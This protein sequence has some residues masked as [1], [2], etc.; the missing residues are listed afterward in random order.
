MQGN[1]LANKSAIDRSKTDFYPIGTQ[2]GERSFSIG[3]NLNMC[4]R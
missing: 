3:I 2:E 4:Y 1:I